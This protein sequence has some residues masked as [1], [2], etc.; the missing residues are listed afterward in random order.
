M[1]KHNRTGRHSTDAGI[2]FKQDLS[3]YFE[4]LEE[5][6][7][8]LNEIC[9]IKKGN[10]YLPL[11]LIFSLGYMKGKQDE[12]ARRKA[13]KVAPLTASENVVTKTNL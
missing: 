11:G 8:I 7:K 12:R 3:P 5:V 10:V 1:R 9:P 2:A 4:E 13:A 6:N